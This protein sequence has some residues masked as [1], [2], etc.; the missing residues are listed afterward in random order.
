MIIID[1]FGLPGSGKTTTANSIA[2]Y[3]LSQNRNCHKLSGVDWFTGEY[4]GSVTKHRLY[5]I[6]NLLKPNSISLFFTIINRYR[7]GNLLC[8]ETLKKIFG[9]CCY[10][11]QLEV[12]NEDGIYITDNGLFQTYANSFLFSHADDSFVINCFKLF[13]KRNRLKKV[14]FYYIEEKPELCADRVFAREKNI[15]IKNSNLNDAILEMR[16]QEAIMDILIN[17]ARESG[18]V[19][20]KVKSCINQGEAEIIVKE[21][22]KCEAERL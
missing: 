6:F 5:M 12:L 14:F 4:S 22:L 7:K 9:I 2:S 10:Y 15:R 11:S 18:L 19:I 8:R 1:L 13:V 17:E 20:K 16:R 3:F 21:V